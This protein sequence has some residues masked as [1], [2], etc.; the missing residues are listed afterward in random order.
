M[1]VSARVDK[2]SGAANRRIDNVEAAFSSDIAGYDIEKTGS[3][4]QLALSGRSRISSCLGVRIAATG[5]YLPET[6]VTN[7]DLARLGCDSDWIVQRTGILE[8][9]RAAADEATSDLAFAAAV[10]CLESANVAASEVDLIVVATITPDH[11]TPS[12]GCI[13]QHRLGCIAP[14]LDVNAACSGFVY[15]LVTASQFVANGAAK[16]ALVIGAEMMTQTVDPN[17]KRTYPL[18]GD[19]AG[20]VLLQA[21]DRKTDAVATNTSGAAMLDHSNRSGLLAYTLGSEGVGGPQL[22]IPGGGSRKPLSADAIA[23]GQQYLHMDGRS[24]F[25]WAVRIIRDSCHDLLTHTGLS[26]EDMSAWILHQANIRIIDA[27]MEEFKIDRNRLVINVDKL[28]N[29]SA[30]SVPLALHQACLDKKI[31]PDDLVMLCGFGA[32]LTWGTAIWRW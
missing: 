25:K 28:G 4:N 12:T 26:A 10:N 16:N 21:D 19:G 24:V 29:T 7:S 9:R 1:N 8:R 20:A 22:C 23:A 31:K 6:I 17:D 11:F 18:F 14:A 27:A 5:A 3:Q 32:G 15:A 2:N 13:L 30:A